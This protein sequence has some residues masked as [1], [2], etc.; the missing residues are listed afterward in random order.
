LQDVL[1][2]TSRAYRITRRIYHHQGSLPIHDHAALIA[3]VA[4]ATSRAL[5]SGVCGPVYRPHGNPDVPNPYFVG[6][7]SVISYMGVVEICTM[8]AKL[9][10]TGSL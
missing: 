7:Q 5:P 10:A 2:P 3:L 8:A 4:V 9:R 6:Q 1:N